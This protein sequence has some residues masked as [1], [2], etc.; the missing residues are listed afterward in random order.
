MTRLPFIFALRYL[1]AHKSFKII[2]LISIVG[3]A[4]MALGTA[5]LIIVLSVFNGFNGLVADSL[6][7]AGAPL[8][9]RPAEGKVF[10][11]EGPAFEWIAS[12]E[13]IA[14]S[15]AVLEEQ[16]FLSFEGRQSLARVRGLDTA[17]EAESPLRQHIV[18]GEWELHRGEMPQAIAGASLAYNLGIRPH[19]VTPLEIHYP[20]RTQPV[21]LTNP[22]A[23]LRSKKVQLSG[24]VSINASLDASLLVVPVEVLRDLLEYDKEVSAIEIWPAG[25]LSALKNTLQEQLGPAFRVLDRQE[26]DQS[27]FRMMRYEKLAI[28]LILVFI[29]LIVA[30]NIYSSLK[31]LIIEKEADTYTLRSLGAPES[32]LRR[33]FLT[34]GWLVSVLGMLVG[35]ALGVAVVLLQQRFGLVSLPGN[36]AVSA[37]PVSLQAR[38]LLWTVAGVSVIGLLMAL[39][40]SR[41]I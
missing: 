24:I 14:R 4:G 11:P 3:A 13:D 7:D 32:M 5:A 41:K 25:D 35:L 8:V 21:S 26:Q 39:I 34:E 10:V 15:T 17:G 22:A 33:I 40:P 16:V 6:A 1:L 27:I 12:F 2:N 18:D 37:Y 29:V 9:V 23:S 31:M 36:F 30:F 19:F 20:S 28:Y 38:D